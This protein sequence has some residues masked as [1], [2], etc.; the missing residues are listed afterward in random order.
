MAPNAPP[1]AGHHAATDL[2]Q[3]LRLA[4][5]DLHA[6]SERSGL[7]RRLV[8][9]RADRAAYALLLRSLHEIYVALESA[10]DQAQQWPGLQRLNLPELHRRDALANDLE[11]VHGAGWRDELAPVQAALDYAG[12]LRETAAQRPLALAAH[13][14]VRWLGD[15]HGGQILRR[16]VER[17]LGLQS[18]E[19]GQDTRPG[20]NFYCFGPPQRVLEL[21]QLLRDALARLDAGEAAVGMLIEEARWSFRQHCLMFEEL[22]SP[23]MNTA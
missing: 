11:V 21:R 15:L 23:A 2:P 12:R 14:Y 22:D 20:T 5:Q 13:A 18:V 9:G 17:S 16:V 8:A 7:M 10:L 1:S 4:T 6:L 3:Q 19:T